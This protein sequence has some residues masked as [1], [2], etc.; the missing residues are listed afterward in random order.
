MQ[1]GTRGAEE[2]PKFLVRDKRL[3]FPMLCQVPWNFRLL[4]PKHRSNFEIHNAYNPR[5]AWNLQFDLGIRERRT[6]RNDDAPFHNTQ[7]ATKET[8]VVFD[9]K[10]LGG[11][12][13]I[14]L[15]DTTVRESWI[16]ADN[17]S[18]NQIGE[19]QAILA[20]NPCVQEASI[21]DFGEGTKSPG[22]SDFQKLR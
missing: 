20:S 22:S 11:R 9:Q 4:G 19:S 5:L 2:L 6:D 18:R 14:G 21:A 3:R 15:R 7:A 8:P 10:Y 13:A 16:H 1:L 17:T 12:C